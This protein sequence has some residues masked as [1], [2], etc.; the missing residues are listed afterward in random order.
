MILRSCPPTGAWIDARCST[1]TLSIIFDEAENRLRKHQKAIDTDPAQYSPTERRRLGRS[2]PGNP[3]SCRR[4]V[5]CGAGSVCPPRCRPPTPRPGASPRK[6]PAPCP[7]ASSVPRADALGHLLVV[8]HTSREGQQRAQL[9]MSRNRAAS[10]PRIPDHRVLHRQA[11]EPSAFTGTGPSE[12]DG[13][14]ALD[15]LDRA[16][17]VAADRCAGCAG[18]LFLALQAAFNADLVR[19]CLLVPAAD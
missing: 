13:V 16:R 12:H 9:G 19:W 6:G 3:S 1:A 8:V 11:E 7:P 2:R 10:R 14:P 15:H 4:G 18:P 5:P 17:Q